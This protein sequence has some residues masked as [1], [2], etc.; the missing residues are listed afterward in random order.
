MDD[1]GSVHGEGPNAARPP[2]PTPRSVHALCRPARC[3]GARAPALPKVSR[4]P[5]NGRNVREGQSSG[6]VPQPRVTTAPRG[7]RK[8][9]LNGARV[10]GRMTRAESTELGAGAV[11]PSSANN[12]AESGPSNEHTVLPRFTRTTD[13]QT[14]PPAPCPSPSSTSMFARSQGAKPSSETF[15]TRESVAQGC[16]AAG[17]GVGLGVTVGVRVG[18]VVATASGA[19]GTAETVA[20]TVRDSRPVPASLLQARRIRHSAATNA[21]PNVRV[22]HIAACSQCAPPLV[23]GNCVKRRPRS[24]ALTYS[25]ASADR[26]PAASAISRCRGAPRAP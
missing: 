18:R 15:V 23:H 1:W 22:R 24:T 12:E 17:V 9:A 3:A 21:T 13:C 8:C 10:G 14:R 2:T 20:V 5:E 4:T 7:F 16:R 19:L 26:A 6:H 25:S 11:L